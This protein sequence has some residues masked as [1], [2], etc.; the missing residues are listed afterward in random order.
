M[1]CEYV[2]NHSQIREFFTSLFLVA[3]L[4]LVSGVT[5]FASAQMFSVSD[6]ERSFDIPQT[7]IYVG[8][9]PASFEYKGADAEL[10]NRG[11]FEF[12]GS[13][14]RL[15]LESR[16]LDLFMASGGSLTGVDDISYFEAGIR[17]YYRLPV[18]TQ[19][20]FTLILPVQLLSNLTTVTDRESIGNEPNFRQGGFVAGGGV[21]AMFRPIADFRI[22]AKAVP[23]Y[24]F[25][26]ATGGT[27]GGSQA[28]AE[29]GVRISRD[30]LFNDIGLSI[31]YDYNVRSYDIDGDQ[32]DYDFAAHSILL[33]VT[34]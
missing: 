20:K 9:E 2:I 13:L 14:V 16:G 31:G 22:E 19:E 12:D 26:F 27:F 6:A 7:G 10:S 32:F 8:I 24:G 11:Q 28:L 1:K 33:G 17:A 23:S 25:S 21:E 29:A 18:I 5:H 3:F 4:L 34:F 15:R 30:R